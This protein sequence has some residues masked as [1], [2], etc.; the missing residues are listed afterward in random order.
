MA[1]NREAVTSAAVSLDHCGLCGVGQY[2][3]VMEAE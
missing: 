3:E 2:G 1:T